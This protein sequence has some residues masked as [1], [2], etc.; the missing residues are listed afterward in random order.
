MEKLYP[1]WRVFRMYVCMYEKP[2]IKRKGGEKERVGRVLQG[3]WWVGGNAE[4]L[5]AQR[6]VC[7]AVAKQRSE[8]G[9]RRGERG[10]FYYPETINCTAVIVG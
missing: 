6:A 7:I 10:K 1:A 2:W 8:G 4:R 9:E 5:E 3:C